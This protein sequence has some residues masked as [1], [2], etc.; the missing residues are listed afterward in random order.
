MAFFRTP[1]KINDKGIFRM[2][3]LRS[4]AFCKMPLKLLRAFFRTPS[5]ADGG[6]S[7]NALKKHQI[8]D[9][10]NQA[11]VL[12]V[13]QLDQELSVIFNHLTFHMFLV[14]YPYL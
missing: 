14:F 13:N 10:P 5:N 8:K 6:I 9:D 11:I 2:P 1:L 7:I 3:K 4:E 12:K